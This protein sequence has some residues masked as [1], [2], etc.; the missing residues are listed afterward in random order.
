MTTEY[1]V[2]LRSSDLVQLRALLAE[3]N[4]PDDDCAEQLAGICGIFDGSELIAA[5]GL[6][7]VAPY[8]LLRSVV[9]HRDYRGQGLA[10]RLTDYLLLRAEVQDVTAVYLL[11]E[12]A[13]DYFARIGFS[14]IER[15]R[16]PAEV[17][18]TRQF[19]S[20][21]PQTAACMSMGLPRARATP[22]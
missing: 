1:I 2:E 8:A 19:A 15:A 21:C 13:Q 10:Q 16:V 6:E 12:T 11:T 4:L 18:Q 7:L 5:G 20:L 22:V 14:H 3:N 9:V 17:Q